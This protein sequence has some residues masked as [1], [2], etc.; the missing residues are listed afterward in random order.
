MSMIAP[1]TY[2]N[3]AAF[4]A[5]WYMQQNPDLTKAGLT[6]PEQALAHYINYGVKEGRVPNPTL[7]M[8]V[9]TQAPGVRPLNVASLSEPT[10]QALFAMTQ[11]PKPINPRIGQL[12]GRAEESIGRMGEEYDPNSYKTYMNPFLQ[13]VLDTTQAD[14]ERQYEL[15]RARAREELAASGGYGSTALGQAYAELGEA[16]NRQLG[17]QG[18]ALRA[19]G[20]DTANN[21]ALDVFRTNQANRTAQGSQFMNLAGSMQGLDE[22]GRNVDIT[23]QNRMLAAGDRIQMQNQNVLDSYFNEQ[24][25]KFNYPMQT[26]QYLQGV[27]GAYPTGQTQTTTTPGVGMVQGGIGGALLGSQI[28]NYFGKTN[29]NLYSAPI[30]PTMTGAPMPSYRL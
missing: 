29:P 27:L 16:Q 3:P 28:G 14:T 25:G 21:R 10:Q 18:A 17:T 5:A 11:A 19:M 2:E 7:Q 22:Y 13:E 24:A 12:Y 4:N 30:G 15:S 23:G 9:E 26:N 8:Q 1:I 20:F 6:T